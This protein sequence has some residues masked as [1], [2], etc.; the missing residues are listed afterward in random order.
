MEEIIEKLKNARKAYEIA[1]E[2]DY[3]PFNGD[4]GYEE[5]IDEHSG[6]R[7]DQIADYICR[8]IDKL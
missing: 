3:C 6:D 2:Y 5:G 7:P 4:D 1:L 8:L